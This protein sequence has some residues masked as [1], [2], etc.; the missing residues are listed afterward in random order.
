[1]DLGA[2]T[3]D[4]WLRA[5]L[6]A[7]DDDGPR[8]D[9]V[10]KHRAS[11]P[12]RAQFIELGL[13]IAASR[14]RGVEA[15]EALRRQAGALAR[16][17]GAA[18]AGPASELKIYEFRR[19]FVET[20]YGRPRDVLAVAERLWGAQP[21]LDLHVVDTTDGLPDLLAW[22]GLERLRSLHVCGLGLRDRDAEVIAATPHLARLR[23][24]DLTNNDIGPEGFFAIA[25]R[26]RA[27]RWASFVNNIV[28]DPLSQGFEAP[29]AGLSDAG[30]EALARFGPLPW[31]ASPIYGPFGPPFP[32][33]L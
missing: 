17:H 30:R 31:L 18:W 27:L 29:E 28:V 24:I 8:L 16:A 3:H 5:I 22:P 11:Q 13:A 33:Q 1:M 26:M 10:A 2:S 6:D 4:P 25:D 20:V 12:E 9:W 21:I 19:G 14:R 23:R 7:P 15:P 32:E